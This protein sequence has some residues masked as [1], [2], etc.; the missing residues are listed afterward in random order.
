MAW[1]FQN[2]EFNYYAKGEMA[3]GNK[4][5]QKQEKMRELLLND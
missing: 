4:V 2:G 3:D 1:K 5:R